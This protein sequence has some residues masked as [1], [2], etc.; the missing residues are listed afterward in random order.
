MDLN[1]NDII[2]GKS[3]DSCKKYKF[4]SKLNGQVED[5]Q[6]RINVADV[7]ELWPYIMYFNQTKNDQATNG[8]LEFMYSYPLGEKKA[9]DNEIFVYFDK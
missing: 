2:L 1:Q 3:K 8:L 7:F 9:K 4:D 6:N 5:E